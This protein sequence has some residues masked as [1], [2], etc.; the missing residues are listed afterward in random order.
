MEKSRTKSE[1]GTQCLRE[2]GQGPRIDQY[3]LR[4]QSSQSNEIQRQEANHSSQDISTPV[5]DVRRTCMDTVSDE[6]NDPCEP[7]QT[8]QHKREKNLNGHK[9]GVKWPR[10]CEKTA[11]DTVNTDLCVALERLSGTVEK[12][13]DKF[14]D[15]IYAYGTAQGSISGTLAVRGS[16]FGA[17]A[18]LGAISGPLVARSSLSVALVMLGSLSGAL[19]VQGS[20]SWG[21]DGAEEVALDTGDT[22]LSLWGSGAGKIGHSLLGGT[23]YSPTGGTGLSASSCTLYLR[24]RPSLSDLASPGATP[25]AVLSSTHAVLGSMI[26]QGW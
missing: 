18:M 16:L 24:Q 4:S 11:W 7:G 13:L 6:P 15:I 9:P 25:P 20:F 3:F 12:K 2:K 8:N 1:G 17:L 23:G 21:S 19:V 5:I 14:G 22:G 10:A 26:R